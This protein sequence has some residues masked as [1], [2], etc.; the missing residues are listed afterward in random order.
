[1]VTPLNPNASASVPQ[2]AAP[3]EPGESGSLSP[4]FI[5]IP[6]V[7]RMFGIKR[8][9]CYALISAGKVKSV[10]LRK[11]GAKTGIRLV[12]VASLREYLHKRLA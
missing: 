2:T 12:H 11:P 8:G 5:R 4:E 10:C 3:I 1:M 7:Q 9:H 6:C